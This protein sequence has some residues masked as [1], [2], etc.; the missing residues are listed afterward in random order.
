MDLISHT[1]LEIVIFVSPSEHFALSRP[2]GLFATFV[3]DNPAAGD[4]IRIAMGPKGVLIRF[5]RDRATE[6][7]SGTS[8]HIIDDQL[9]YRLSQGIAPS[10]AKLDQHAA[11][12]GS[13]H[14]S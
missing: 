6:L 13:K 10:A 11:G 1:D 2:S 4:E 12:A 9:R 3:R 5:P 14:D 7:I 8:S